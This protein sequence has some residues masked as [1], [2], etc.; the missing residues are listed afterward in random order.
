MSS[1]HN[2]VSGSSYR[3]QIIG[4]SSG[5]G[6]Y[7][8]TYLSPT[9]VT[10]SGSPAITLGGS[11]TYKMLN[12]VCLVSGGH[13][14]RMTAGQI[15]IPIYYR[16]ATNGSGDTV[17]PTWLETTDFTTYT[18]GPICD[19][20][21]VANQGGIESTIAETSAGNTYVSCRD[22]G[23][24][25]SVPGYRC[26]FLHTSGAGTLAD[27]VDETTQVDSST[28]GGI[29]R[30]SATKHL[31]AHQG[32]GGFRR[33]ML[34]QASTNGCSTWTA[35]RLVWPDGAGY[36]SLSHIG[37]ERVLLVYEK[38][39][40]GEALTGLEAYA[41][42]I[43]IAVLSWSDIVNNTTSYQYDY[44]FDEYGNGTTYPGGTS[45]KQVRDKGLMGF[46]LG[47]TGTVTG[48]STGA[49]IASGAGNYVT[50]N[51]YYRTNFEPVVNQSFA[52]EVTFST[53]D[54]NGFLIAANASGASRWWIGLSAGVAFFSIRNSADTVTKTAVGSANLADGNSH[55]IS[56]VYVPGTGLYIVEDG[57]AQATV[58]DGGAITFNG[59]DVR[60]ISEDNAGANL[61]QA[62]TISRLRVTVGSVPSPLI[63]GQSVTRSNFTAFDKTTLANFPSNA[64]ISHSGYKLLFAPLAANHLFADMSYSRP[65]P[66]L[67]PNMIV[68]SGFDHGAS[69]LRWSNDLLGT[70]PSGFAPGF[71]MMYD[72]DAT[73]GKHFRTIGTTHQSVFRF[74]GSRSAV[75]GTFNFMIDGTTR[76]WTWCCFVKPQTLDQNGVLF[77]NSNG[78]AAGVDGVHFRLANSGGGYS[79]FYGRARAGGVYDYS[80]VFSPSAHATG[81]NDAAA[82]WFLCVVYDSTKVGNAKVRG[83]IAKVGTDTTI[84]STHYAEPA[85]PTL[86]APNGSDTDAYVAYDNGGTGHYYGRFGAMAI[87]NTAWT[88][89]QVQAFYDWIRLYQGT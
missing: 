31:L 14:I 78:I 32:Q 46:N 18:L 60:R 80:Q 12:A 79:T 82:W 58:A 41:T 55:T 34:I 33:G 42:E 77:D 86:T 48:A 20:T 85:T 75:N 61:L 44:Y 35:G 40:N 13:A 39:H 26:S 67:R 50:M 51:N 56:C 2:L 17:Y 11:A 10:V 52:V 73:V 68:R 59:V 29:C 88:L 64:T 7:T 74:T 6:I 54:A 15:R 87:H 25:G 71:G 53:S 81:V 27:Q 83:Y 37:N 45:G 22:R 69:N 36:C 30:I 49:T 3:I 66:V 28:K 16:Y 24:T 5:S 76:Q 72:S 38:G 21:K 65:Q 70:Y 1:A 84:G 63:Y 19:E 47:V 23:Q 43:G 9:T 62:L 57:V 89:S 8:C 4:A